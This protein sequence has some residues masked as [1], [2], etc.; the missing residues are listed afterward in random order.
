VAQSV[1]AGSAATFKVVGTG[2]SL[3]YQWRRNGSAIT[4]ATAASYTVPAAVTDDD[5]AMFSA[6]VSNSSGTATS[7]AAKLTVLP[8]TPANGVDVAMYKYDTSRTGQNVNESILTTANVNP[9]TFGLVHFIT[10]DGKVNAQPLYL[11][12]LTV[13]GA[14]HNVIFIATEHG[15][16]YAVDASTYAQLWKVSLV[17]AGH[18]PSD[19]RSC[20][21]ITP[22]IGITSTPTIDRSAG[23]HG[24]MYVVAMSKDSGSSY[25]QV[26]HALD[27]TTGA[28]VTTPREITATFTDSSGH[29]TTFEPGQ[30]EERTAL[31]LSNGTIYTEWSSHCDI[32]LYGGW[33]IT[34]DQTTFAQTGVLNV[35]PGSA[36]SAAPTE[37]V[38]PGI[39]MSGGGPAVDAA[40]RVLLITGNGPFDTTLNA[41][42][43]PVNGNYAQSFLK[44]QM[45]GSG[46]HIA[47]YF[48]LYDA[49]AKSHQDLDVGA[50]GG[51]LLPEMTDSNNQP[52]NLYLGG[53]K[54]GTVYVLDQKRFGGF[55]ATK[56]DIYQE[57]GGVN[58]LRSTPA[59]FNNRVYF[60]GQNATLKSFTFTQARMSTSPSSQTTMTF[61]YPGTS[62]VVSANGTTNG[63]VWAAE[64]DAAQDAV[65]H[66]F[67]A[68]NLA[69][70][71]YKSTPAGGRDSFGVANRF[72]T[73]VVTGGKVYVASTTGVAVFGLLH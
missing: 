18:S 45:D 60:G 61:L 1:R 49:V 65:L 53:G 32:P 41:A 24:V 54:G 31:L 71:L 52:V 11:S 63:I 46:L 29:V 40:G 69:T 56:N 17:P 44:L 7:N 30:Y 8:V 39:W 12:Q 64:R 21:Q 35:G 50:G 15:S 13:G 9:S 22:E 68:M 55:N 26:L 42:G 34:Y 4:G 27:I 6:V 20:T 58:P 5:A 59:Y 3:T 38:G 28:D 70:E 43:H 37:T 51:L 23:A 48:A 73:P 36:D 66:A 72:V 67:D 19:N 47:D 14:P 57:V 62:P 10:T 2:T 33:I 16:V 25:H